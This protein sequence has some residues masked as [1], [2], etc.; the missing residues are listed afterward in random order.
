MEA[1][2]LYQKLSA[3]IGTPPTSDRIPR[4]WKMICDE[5]EAFLLLAMPGTVEELSLKTG[6]AAD[7]VGKMVRVLFRKGV[8]FE[9]E[10]GGTVQYSMPRHLLQ[11]HDA[12]IVWPEAPPEFIALW[13]EFME[14][15]YPDFARA[16]AAMGLASFTRVIP[17]E[18]T[19]QGGS[20]VLPFDSAVK[21][22]EQARRV[23]VT[24]CTCRLTTKK[25]DA[26]VE[27][28]LQLNRA[29]EY[30]IKR[31][32]GREVSVEE[33]KEILR[34]SEEAGLV[35]VTDNRASNEHII[36]NCCSCCCIAL[37]YIKEAGSR[38][39]LAPSRF[40]P[41]VAADRC[42]LC[43]V[44]VDAC[45]VKALSFAPSGAQEQV[46]VKEDLCMGCGQCA[47]RCPETAITLKEV[48]NPDF[49]PGAAA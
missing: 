45:P 44:C 46:R 12:S 18:Q 29:A 36:C 14:T 49:V 22:V 17:V 34:I 7:A 33:A 28:C 19:L 43:G 37:P 41:E 8:V 47:Y 21:I 3:Q 24:N 9:K 38:V 2:A 20:R 4:L 27:V 39:L 40:L 35:H 42:T 23:A 30:T 1:Q 13:Q 10:K 31:G 48:R 32:S 11:F 15:E 25:C 6:I 5:Q 16:L 26:P